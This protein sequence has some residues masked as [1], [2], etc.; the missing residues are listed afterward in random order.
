M[1]SLVS[2]LST[3]I[4]YSSRQDAKH[5][6]LTSSMQL[7]QLLNE[8]NHL[9][10]SLRCEAE[11]RER[12]LD[13]LASRFETLIA[14]QNQIQ[15]LLS[16]STMKDG[17]CDNPGES[18]DGELTPDLFLVATGSHEGA[19]GSAPHSPQPKSQPLPN[20]SDV[21]LSSEL[22]SLSLGPPS[23]DS[24]AIRLLNNFVCF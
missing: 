22:S 9:R 19:I 6:D 18:D 5:V 16:L 4:T 13:N 8:I 15:P 3:L 23:R 12:D 10:E 11:K 21:C 1:Y 20:S 7:Q 24:S 17:G 14:A 2:P